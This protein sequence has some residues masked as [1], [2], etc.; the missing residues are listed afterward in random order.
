MEAFDTSNDLAAL[1]RELKCPRTSPVSKQNF[2]SEFITN[3]LELENLQPNPAI[4]R[5]RLGLK[6][7]LAYRYA[8]LAPLLLG[9]LK[10]S[11]T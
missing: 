5:Y 9:D 11:S 3:G 6:M 10:A 4:D 8:M 1:A 2:S 7:A